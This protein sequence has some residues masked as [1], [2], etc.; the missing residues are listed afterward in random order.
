MDSHTMTAP[1]FR[2][3]AATHA[4]AKR[5]HNEDACVDRPDLGLWAV[6]DGA[7]GHAGPALV[8]HSPAIIQV[9]KT[10]ARVAPSQATVL[11]V[12]APV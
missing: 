6:A 8:G 4:G 9:M 10:L 1:R 7:G 12:D 5:T 3:W 2:S 11:V